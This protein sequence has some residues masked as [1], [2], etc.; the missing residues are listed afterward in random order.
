MRFALLCYAP[1][2]FPAEW[3]DEAAEKV[4]EDHNRAQER[5][6]AQ[7]KLGPHLRL[8]PPTTALTI[9]SDR[10]PMVMD[11]PF[12]ETKEQLLG[13]WIFEADSLEEAIEIGREYAEHGS[14][15]ELRPI[16]EYF[17]ENFAS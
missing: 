17:P 15:I 13:F 3:T 14:A 1:F 5:H 12:T 9:R 2:P 16:M 6:L 8:M 7:R 10:E 11:G 4:M